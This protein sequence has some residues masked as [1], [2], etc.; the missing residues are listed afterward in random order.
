[1]TADLRIG[2]DDP[3]GGKAVG[4]FKVVLGLIFEETSNCTWLFYLVIRKFLGGIEL[5]GFEVWG[6]KIW[7]DLYCEDEDEFALPGDCIC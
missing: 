5:C 4:G 7:L 2:C 3:L 6:A 1:M